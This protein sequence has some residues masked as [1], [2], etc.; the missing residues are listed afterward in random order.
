[1][2]SRGFTGTMPQLEHRPASAAEWAAAMMVPMV[3]LAAAAAGFA[4]T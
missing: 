1:M 3:S 2:L 4:L